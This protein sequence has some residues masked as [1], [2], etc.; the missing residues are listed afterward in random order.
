MKLTDAEYRKIIDYLTEYTTY[1][2]G[3]LV[4]TQDNALWNMKRRIEEAMSRYPNEIFEY[5]QKNPQHQPR[6]TKDELKKMKY[7]QLVEIRKTLKIRKGKKVKSQVSAPDTAKQAREAIK[8]Q[9]TSQTVVNVMRSNRD[10]EVYQERELEFVT[11]KEAVEMYGEDVTEEYLEARGYKLYES[12]SSKEKD[13]EEERRYE[14][15]ET[16]LSA[17]ITVQGIP[18]TALQLLKLETDELNYICNIVGKIEET[19]T[20]K[21]PKK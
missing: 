13:S 10:A 2:V 12:Y 1:D 18:L 17:N 6:Y 9:T 4:Q 20:I 11:W 21:G 5:Y 15:I 8:G 14:M 3:N 7:N 19:L 16:I